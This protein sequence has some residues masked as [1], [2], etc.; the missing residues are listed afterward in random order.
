MNVFLLLYL[1]E[2][3][4]SA[5]FPKSNICAVAGLALQNPTGAI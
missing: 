2:F 3:K 1:N 5:G 4:F